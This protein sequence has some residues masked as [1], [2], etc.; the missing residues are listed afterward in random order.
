VVN[1]IECN[2]RVGGSLKVA[3]MDCCI[4][5]AGMLSIDDVTYIFTNDI[6]IRITYIKKFEIIFEKFE[7]WLKNMEISLRPMRY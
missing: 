2:V 4:C 6:K 1:Q 5:K 7:I 3:S